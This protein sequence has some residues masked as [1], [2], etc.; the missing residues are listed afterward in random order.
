MRN[1]RPNFQPASIVPHGEKE[2]DRQ[3]IRKEGSEDY[4]HERWEVK[5]GGEE[6]RV[7]CE[8]EE[9]DEEFVEE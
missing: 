2:V 7:G 3:H 5:M 4:E 8:G 6:C 1:R 9:G